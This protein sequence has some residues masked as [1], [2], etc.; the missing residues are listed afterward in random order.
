MTSGTPSNTPDDDM[1]DLCATHF[2]EDGFK[3]WQV[4]V[5]V[6][7]GGYAHVCGV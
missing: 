2:F 1:I 5:N 3:R 7:Q 6:V 4:S